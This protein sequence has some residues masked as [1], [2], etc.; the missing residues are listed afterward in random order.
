MR[1]NATHADRSARS[2]SSL[3]AKQRHAVEAL[4]ASGEV[5]SAAHTAGVSRT[6]L[7]RWLT[8]PVFISAI[9][10]AEAQALDDLSRMLVRLGAT[11]AE[12]L[13]Q[14]MSDSTTPPATRIRAADAVLSR[15]LQIR[16]LATLEARV[17]E[18]ERATGL[19]EGGG[20]ASGR[21]GETWT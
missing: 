5:T 2:S 13:A 17:N 4:L 6:T 18:L 11:A 20:T 21:R 15:L 14:A 7:H 3:S 9:R 12:T 1:Q 19:D 16:E 10:S 8:E